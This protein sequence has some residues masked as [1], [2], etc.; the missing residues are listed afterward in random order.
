[1]GARSPS[2]LLAD[3]PE[4]QRKEAE[5]TRTAPSTAPTHGDLRQGFVYERMPHI[6]LKS[7]ANNAEI[8]VI[9][10]RFQDTL[11][12]LRDALNTA[13]GTAWEE[14]KIPREAGD[15]WSDNARDLH[16]QWWQARMARK[17]EIDASIAAKADCEYLYDKP[18]TDNARIRVAGPF[19]VES[20]SPHRVF[21]VDQDDELQGVA[22]AS[23]QYHPSTNGTDDGDFAPMVLDHLKTAGV[24]QAHKDDKIAFTSITGCSPGFGGCCRRSRRRW[25]PS[26]RRR[27]RPRRTG[28][29]P[30]RTG[31]RFTRCRCGAT[32]K[33]VGPGTVTRPLMGL[34]AKAN[35]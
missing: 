24:Q 22:E 26:G 5:I 27:C 23:G 6:T 21:T 12:P 8:D 33:T 18:Y 31:V 7:I 25:T 28:S 4:G 17:Q 15:D 10:E 3:T 14:W 9:W 19:T 20:L 2:Y 29:R 35:S 32:P 1:M 34:G 16:A 30:R 11:E 13:L